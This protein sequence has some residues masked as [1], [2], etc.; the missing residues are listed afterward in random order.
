VQAGSVVE[1]F[2]HGKKVIVAI[3][4]ITGFL[5][6]SDTV[7]TDADQTDPFETPQLGLEASTPGAAHEGTHF[8]NELI[9][10]ELPRRRFL[11]GM[12]PFPLRGASP[13]IDLVKCQVD[14]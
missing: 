14:P 12:L 11:T 5:G 9:E 2:Q 10:F 8:V 4:K 1:V 13:F 6:K 3:V 7:R